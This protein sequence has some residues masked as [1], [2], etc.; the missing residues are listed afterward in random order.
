[1][2]EESNT[3]REKG[4]VF[5]D[6]NGIIHARVPSGL[7]LG[8]TIRFIDEIVE[9]IGKFKKKSRDLIDI[10]ETNVFTSSQSRKVLA[11][12]IKDI[13]DYPGFA[14]AAIFGGGIIQRTVT[15]FVLSIAQI[16][17]MKLFETKQEALKW[18]KK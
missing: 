2:E 15:S 1:M 9:A 3:K 6:K 12:R 8:G 17:N 5:V 13:I 10:T 14:K 18:L 11:G 16:K 4:N 7:D